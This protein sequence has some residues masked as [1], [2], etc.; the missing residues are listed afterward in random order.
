[1]IYYIYREQRYK[2]LLPLNEECIFENVPLIVVKMK[3]SKHE[4]SPNQKSNY[5]NNILLFIVIVYLF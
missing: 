5:Y 1:M 4:I 2:I 3:N